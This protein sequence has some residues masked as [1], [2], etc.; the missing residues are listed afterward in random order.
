MKSTAAEFDL[1]SIY[2]KLIVEILLPVIIGIS[3]QRYW[4]KFALRYGKQLTLFDKSVILLIIYKSFAESF[5]ANIYST[6]HHVDFVLIG[7]AVLVLF[8]VMYFLTGFFARRLHFS[9]EDAITAKFC[10]TKK[11]LVHGTVFSKIL[12][13]KSA[14]VGIIL[15]P[16]ML[17]HAFQLLVISVYAT[18]LSKRNDG[19]AEAG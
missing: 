3:L 17:F 8:Y 10:G 14:A 9:A 7:A 6:I 12:F 1:G 16:L 19:V 11:S 15:L 4:G 2:F 5:E 18:R 13:A